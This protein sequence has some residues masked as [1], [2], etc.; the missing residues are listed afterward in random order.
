MTYKTSPWKHLT[1]QARLI[2]A[3]WMIGKAVDITPKDHPDSEAIYRAAIALAE[4][5][6]VEVDW[7]YSDGGFVSSPPQDSVGGRLSDDEHLMLRDGEVLLKRGGGEFKS[8][9]KQIAVND[10]SQEGQI[11]DG[12]MG[13]YFWEKYKDHYMEIAEEKYSDVYPS[14]GS[15][16]KFSIDF[17]PVSISHWGL[18]DLGRFG[19]VIHGDVMEWHENGETFAVT[20]ARVFLGEK[21]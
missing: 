1:D 20:S 7:R 17:G 18:L 14:N 11:N 8:I 5:K 4:R 16:N 15:S 6:P 21:Q 12:E 13:Q 2:I 9:A 10:P 3:E 19:A